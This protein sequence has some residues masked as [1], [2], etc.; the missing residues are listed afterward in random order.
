MDEIFRVADRAVVLRNGKTVGER[1]I[2]ETTERDLVELMIEGSV[3]PSKL[4]TQ[5]IA[6]DA[7]IRLEVR[8]LRTKQLNG[9]SLTLRAG[10]LLGLGGL[11][12]QGQTDLLLAIF[13]AINRSGDI[14]LEKEKRSFLHPRQAMQNGIAYVPGDRGHEGLMLGRPIL[15]NF[16]LPSWLRYGALLNLERARQNANEVADQLKLV[17]ASL[18]VPVSTLSGGNAQKV[19]LGKWL[20]RSPRLLLLNDPTKGVDVGAKGEIYSLLTELREAG[21]AILFYSSDDEELLGLCDRVLVLHDG[22][23]SAELQGDGLDHASLV[24]ASMG[25]A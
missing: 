4:N 19:V 25:T 2:A 16:Q 5:P 13:G 22:K 7:P 12:G 9:V 21:T 23:I 17:R 1:V 3:A 11:Q 18:D 24:A 8:D 14:I 15:E 20:L 10:E 6:E